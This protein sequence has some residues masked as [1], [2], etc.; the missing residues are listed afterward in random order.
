M[1]AS[2]HDPAPC[3]SQSDTQ[4]RR[5]LETLVNNLEGMLIRCRVDASW[6]MLF[7]SEGCRSLTGYH[8][9]DLLG[10]QRLSY[11]EITHPED[12]DHVREQLT[13]AARMGGSYRVEYRI[14][15]ADGEIRWVAEHGKRGLDENGE[16]VLESYIEDV[17]EQIEARNRLALAEA[18]YRS[19]FEHS[20]EGI[21]QTTAA[22]CYLSANPALAAI[23]GYTSP[24]AL[25]AE[26]NDI[27]NQLYLRPEQRRRFQKMME[28][29]GAVHDFESEIRRRDGRVIWISENARSVYGPDG[30]FLYYEGTVRDI[31][32]SKLHQA[33]L[34]YHAT[35][36]QLT[37]LPNRSLLGDRLEQ[38]IR[39]A[40]RNSQYC[41]VA[42]FDLDNFKFIN[43]SLGH[44]VGDHLLLELSKRLRAC[45]RETDTVARYG[46]DEFILVLSG[47]YSMGQITR[48][49]ERILDTVKR[50]VHTAGQ[51]MYVTCSLGVSLFPSD[52]DDTQTLLQHADAAMY[53][54]KEQGKNNFR[55]YTKRLNI[56]ANQRVRLEHNLHRALDRDEIRVFFQPKFHRDGHCMGVEALARWHSEELGPVPPSQFIQ[57]A[58]ECGL[59]APLTESVLRQACLGMREWAIRAEQPLSLAVNLSGRVF[60]QENLLDMVHGILRDTRFPSERLEF[61]I[62]E[63]ALVD[64]I[65]HCVDVLQT[66]KQ[67]GAQI[68]MDDFGTGYSSLRYLQRFPIDTL[69]ID[70]SFIADLRDATSAPPILRAI[71]SLAQNLDMRTVAEGVEMPHQLEA[72]RAL[73]C[74]AY[75]GFLF[76]RPMPLEALLASGMLARSPAPAH[77]AD[78]SAPFAGG[79]TANRE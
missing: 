10:N 57:I 47:Y 59:I 37:G 6:T 60:R 23:Y 67:L 17:T 52:G 49:L 29:E 40:R 68:A 44:H 33:T 48:V 76:A 63:S 78:K 25:M 8:P 15:R 24:D 35:H 11:E 27:G 41:V 69:K 20:R 58:E 77:G 66:L 34:E 79:I 14:L 16:A 21:F 2:H 32:E 26:L 50:P 45:L 4:V 54:A 5:M 38:A 43:D 1:P 18:R 36:D 28:E 73:G 72:L 55:F 65:E 56:L 22:G 70:R 61:E 39:L 19:V 51:E 71:V 9:A 3:P 12:R 74:D 7:I 75:Q 42:F 62:T 64:D 46:G 30:Q 13:M 31:T 53:L